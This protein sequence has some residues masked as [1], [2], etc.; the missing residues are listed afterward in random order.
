[1]NI[2]MDKRNALNAQCEY[3]LYDRNSRNTNQC[4]LNIVLKEHYFECAMYVSLLFDV[5]DCKLEQREFRSFYEH[6]NTHERTWL[7]SI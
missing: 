2:A 5:L 3:L 7:E 6:S 4:S 1:M